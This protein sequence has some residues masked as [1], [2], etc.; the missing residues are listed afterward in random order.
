MRS[1]LAFAALAATAA[2]APSSAHAE[3][4]ATESVASSCTAYIDAVPYTINV[5]GT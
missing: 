3:T 5:P 4:E 1:I 2:F